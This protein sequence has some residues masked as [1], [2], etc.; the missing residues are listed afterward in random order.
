MQERAWSDPVISEFMAKNDG[1]LLDKDGDDSDWIEIHN[2]DSVAVNLAGWRLTDDAGD[3]SK[4]VFPAEILAAGER[5][6]VFASNKNLA[7]AGS[8][9]HTNFKLS[10]SGE[11]LALIKPDNSVTTAFSPNYPEQ[12]S[13]ISYGYAVSQT[14]LLDEAS[15]IEY[16]V[17]NSNIGDIWRQ[18]GFTD[19]NNDFT[20]DAAGMGVGYTTTG[21]YTPGIDVTVPNGTMNVYI[22][23]PFTIATAADLAEI[24]ALLLEM[25]YD[26]A[27]VAWING[28]EVARS[29]GAP[30]TP[31]WNSS[32][33][34]N[35]GATLENPEIYD[36]IAGKSAMQVGS[37]VLAIQIINR[38]NGSSDLLGR[39]SLIASSASTSVSYME[40]TPNAANGDE[41]VPGPKVEEVAHTPL[42][43]LQTDPI[44]VTAKVTPFI[45]SVSG[46]NL[47]YRVMYGSETT[48]VMK[49]DGTGGD[50]L[51]GDTI[52][53]AI[54][55]DSA[56]GQ[57]DMV[58]WRIE[59]TDSDSKV[60][61]APQFL[62]QSG[63]SQSA[64]YYG[65]VIEDASITDSL[66]VMRWFTDD[67]PNSVNRTG[68][69]ASFYYDGQFLDNIYVRQRG[70]FTNNNS[71]KFDF[72]K[73][74]P[75]ELSPEFP[76]VGE[77]NMNS[78]GQDTSYIRQPLCFDTFSKAGVPSC[79]AFPVN[80]RR[81]KSFHKVA[82]YIE[83]V[84]EDYMKR[85]NVPETGALYKFVQRSNL[86]PA[87]NDA[88]TGVEK[89]T[90]DE[91]DF[92]DLEAFISGLKQSL[93]G[94]TIQNTGNL[95]YSAADQAGRKTFL[96][97]NVDVPAMV[98]YLAASVLVQNGDDSRK[99]FYLYR[100]TDGSGEWRQFP[101][102][103]DQSFGVG[104]AN[105]G[106]AKHPL[107][108]DS[109]HKNPNSL[110][111]NVFY[112]ALHNEP[113]IKAM[114]LRRTRTLMDQLYKTSV[115]ENDVYFEPFVLQMESEIDPV[116]NVNTTNL[117]NEIDERR[118][119]LYVNLY[120]PSSS[121]PLIPTAQTAGL[122][123]NFGTIEYN[124]SSGNQDEEYIELTNPNNEDLDISGW[125]IDGG[126]DFVIPGGT[127][128]LANSSLY[129]VA[130]KAAFRN[131][132][133]GPT[134]GQNHLVLGGFSGHLSSFGETV[135]LRDADGG[136]IS[137][138]TYMGNPSDQQL[139]LVVSE[140][141]YQPSANSE[142]E[143]IELMNISSSVTLDLTGVKF[144]EGIVFDFTGSAVTT[145]APG[146]K[147]LVVRNLA[148][149]Q[150][151]YGNGLNAQ[152]AGVYTGG[153]SNAGEEVKLED[154]SNST[155]HD[156]NYEPI[157]PWPTSAAGG[158]S[159]LVLRT[160]MVRPDHNVAAN[161]RAG[162]AQPGVSNIFDLDNWLDDRGSTNASTDTNG[163]G[164]SELLTYAMGKDL[165]ADFKYESK[166]IN[167][168]L[169]LTY[170]MR[171]PMLGVSLKLQ[172]SDALGSW[173]VAILDTDYSVITNISESDGTRTITVQ[174]LGDD[175]KRFL[176]L[177]ALEE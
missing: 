86:S 165:A 11:Y 80:L 116:L 177:R 59:A 124:P 147:V 6:V 101:W 151:T 20:N 117:R 103:M 167:G 54:I 77:V 132:A 58:R 33:S 121:E 41:F 19:P 127:V 172:V 97:D 5:L 21:N 18:N 53:T 43:P 3:T 65:T 89:K 45:G 51:A 17:P 154:A 136:F 24:N 67:V 138:K 13:N 122:V 87:L 73:D 108:A 44:V 150:T 4:W 110:Q 63:T 74:E 169:G 94:S 95:N 148:A 52:Y 29:A 8:E 139:Y 137:S 30:A 36:V 83:Q 66:P 162:S 104:E 26:D 84:D 159:S 7:V 92:S 25:E 152:I 146:A 134:A 106:E 81:N 48:L 126:I 47:Y 88:N 118:Q 14:T 69:R 71:Q 158:G 42:K 166:T 157:V 37:N 107:Y 10:G 39:A 32:S 133:S 31:A 1:G 128:I 90:R 170:S 130:K 61:K 23:V 75:F 40:P 76:K 49:D 176:R 38:P 35:H 12:I 113:T 114:I 143:Y 131:R 125:V 50:V 2:P 168:K 105:N 98:N 93:D 85:Q 149:F 144:T 123:V 171:D 142:A 140:F 56:Y 91:E 60:G 78:N 82:I 62:D 111:W 27:F 135:T 28:V 79:M 15:A 64:E 99:N 173:S 46:V 174:I 161:W 175:P 72:N 155:I 156:F 102:D 9:L 129:V 145:L 120:G 70:G 57:E 100:D 34:Q 68:S 119:D 55:P 115:S 109:Q 141:M 22:R 96:Y 160:P 163:D 164:Y 16:H 153:L 112:D